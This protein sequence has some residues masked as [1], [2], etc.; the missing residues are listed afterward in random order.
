MKINHACFQN[1]CM[2][3]I[4]GLITGISV[5]NFAL[6]DLTRSN[7][8]GGETAHEIA[9]AICSPVTPSSYATVAA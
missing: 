5:S 7:L 3:L 1:S 4:R 2:K 9:F 8:P 6:S